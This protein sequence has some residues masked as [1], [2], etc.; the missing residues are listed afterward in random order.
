MRP[1]IAPGFPQHPSSGL[2]H[3]IVLIDAH[4][5]GLGDIGPLDD[6]AARLDAAGIAPCPGAGGVAPGLAGA[7]IELPAVP[8]AADDLAAAVIAVAAGLVGFDQA[9][10]LAAAKAAALMRAAIEQREVLALD[11]E[12]DDV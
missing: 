1:Q 6:A 4:L 11:V 9:D 5:E 7:E 8:G 3:H 12:D 2:D 10:Q